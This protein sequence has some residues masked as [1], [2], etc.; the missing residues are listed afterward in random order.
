MSLFTLTLQLICLISAV[1]SEEKIV[2]QLTEKRKCKEV[3]ISRIFFVFID[4]YA[5]ICKLKN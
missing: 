1:L 4:A 2:S 3:C 5:K